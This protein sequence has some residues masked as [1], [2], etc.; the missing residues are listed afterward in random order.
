MALLLLPLLLAQSGSSTDEFTAGANPNGWNFASFDVLEAT[1]GNPGGWLHVSNLDTYYPILETGASAAAPWV[2]DLRASGVVRIAFDAITLR[3]DFNTFG[4]PMTVLL[5]DTKGT[6]DVSDDDYAYALGDEMPLVGA[7]WKHFEFAVPSRSTTAVPPGWKGGWAGDGDSFRPGVDWNDLIVAVDRVE[8]WWN[9]PTYFSIFQ[10]WEAGVDNLTIEWRPALALD[11]PT[12]GLAGALNTFTARNAD[13][14]DLVGIAGAL[15]AGS[16]PLPCGG[17][18]TIGG[19]LANPS[20]V[21]AGVADGAG[22]LTLQVFVPPSL[23]GATVQLQ[24]LDRSRCEVSA[25]S[26]ATFQ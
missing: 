12:P 3:T 11:A 9:D 8:V 15:A 24:A 13:A 6:F 10:N 7:G 14:G 21:G 25:V 26:S 4:N 20:L 1:G 19:G 22:V 2:G 16:S 18:R 5:R 23:A 17:G